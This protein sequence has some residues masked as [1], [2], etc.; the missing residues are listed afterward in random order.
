[1]GEGVLGGLF[2]GYVSWSKFKGT[3]NDDWIDRLNHLWTVFL[4]ALFAIFVSTSQFVGNPIY[5]WAPAEFK[6]HWVDYTK[7]ICW[8]SNTYYIP[9]KEVIPVHI[10]ERTEQEL[11]YYQWVPIILLF[12][13]LMFKFPNVLWNIFNDGSGVNVDKV[14]VLAEATQMGSPE[15]REK[16]IK[17]IA[18]YMDRWLETNRETKYNV[19][20]RVRQRLT[21]YCMFFC[22]KKDG[23]YLTGFYMFIK[24]LFCVNV[25]GQ[26][27]L[28]NAFL[29]MEYNLY[30]AEVIN[31]L[32]EKGNL[33]ESP[34][35]PRVTLCDFQI[36]Q[37]QNLLRY[38]VQCVLPINLFNEKIFAFFWFW[39]VL[40][41]TVTIA[42]FIFWLWRVFFLQNKNR[43]CKRYL[44]LLDLIQ[45]G[46]D[47]KLCMN[48]ANHYLRDDGIFVLRLVTKNSTDLV[49]ADLLA[50]LWKIYKDKPYNRSRLPE[51]DEKEALMR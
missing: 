25:I 44:K 40:V 22:A 42:S 29:A 47:K 17:H 19:V 5:C 13:A 15:D 27:F 46:E 21:K 20:V 41:A 43:Y 11:Q 51:D 16:C 34:R 18:I 28:L 2:G 37:L 35:F 6:D 36:R 7:S 1:M 8:V 14:V 3:P 39:L 48:F 33:R 24:L 30:G 45:T 32:S 4:L 9:M 50:H 23:T 10:P 31:Y 38:T 49:T 26:F 12:M